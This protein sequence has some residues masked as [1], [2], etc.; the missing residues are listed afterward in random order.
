[1]HKPTGPVAPLLSYEASLTGVLCIMCPLSIWCSCCISLKAG[2]GEKGQR[3]GSLP[4]TVCLYR[5]PLCSLPTAQVSQPTRLNHTVTHEIHVCALAH[6]RTHI[7]TLVHTPR[8]DSWLP[9]SFPR[10]AVTQGE[11]RERR[12]GQNIIQRR[13]QRAESSGVTMSSLAFSALRRQQALCA[14]QLLLSMSFMMH[15]AGL[16]HHGNCSTGLHWGTL[17]ASDIHH[18]FT[19]N[20]FR[21]LC[22]PFIVTWVFILWEMS[23]SAERTVNSDFQELTSRLKDKNVLPKV[24]EIWFFGN[25]IV[26]FFLM[27]FTLEQK[28]SNVR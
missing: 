10:G 26:V 20:M 27:L 22:V 4:C 7:H 1:M 9:P 28:L 24:T 25:H 13:E 15:N 16:S 12:K 11:R 5:A 14:T 19:E 2:G 21:S 17:S 18:C 6:A 3:R 8:N 23:T